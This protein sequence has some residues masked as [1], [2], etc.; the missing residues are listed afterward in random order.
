MILTN[1]TQSNIHRATWRSCGVNRCSVH[2]RCKPATWR[3]CGV[4]RW[5]LK[6]NVSPGPA[7]ATISPRPPIPPPPPPAGSASFSPCRSISQPVSSIQSLPALASF[8]PCRSISIHPINTLDELFIDNRL[9]RPQA[10]STSFDPFIGD[11]HES[12]LILT[13]AGLLRPL[14]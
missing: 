7:A 1:L 14:H 9:S 10:G 6:W 8:S 11:D 4:N 13:L 5:A 3:S 12:T 2:R